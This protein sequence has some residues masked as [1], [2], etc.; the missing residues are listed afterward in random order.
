MLFFPSIGRGL[1]YKAYITPLFLRLRGRTAHSLSLTR[2]QIWHIFTPPIVISFT[3]FHRGLSTLPVL[4]NGLI[5]AGVSV[6]LCVSTPTTTLCVHW[7]IRT[8][9]SYGF[10]LYHSL[11]QPS[12][13]LY[14]PVFL[15]RTSPDSL[16]NR[17][18]LI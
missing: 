6:S 12:T 18:C 2:R 11:N 9:V 10:N 15:S 8:V 7:V 4:C 1:Y 13:Q 3:V 16:D 14:R 17:L 5:L